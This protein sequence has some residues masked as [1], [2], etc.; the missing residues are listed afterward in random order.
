MV[1]LSFSHSLSLDP[2][3]WS[4]VYVFHSVSFLCSVFFFPSALCFYFNFTNS[5]LVLQ[6]RQ[7]VIILLI[8][9][10]YWSAQ[11]DLKIFFLPFFAAHYHCIW[12]LAVS[13]CCVASPFFYPVFLLSFSIL[14][15]FLLCVA[16]FPHA[17]LSIL[18]QPICNVLQGQH[19]NASDLILTKQSFHIFF[20]LTGR[21]LQ[22]DDSEPTALL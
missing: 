4:S 20:C 21:H 10:S 17:F 12:S 18:S 2:S 19:A 1:F 15:H 22:R 5:W 6:F 13:L 16:L 14:A 8:M 9:R 3:L 11:R 7:L